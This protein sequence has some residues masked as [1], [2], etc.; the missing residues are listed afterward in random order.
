MISKVGNALSDGW[1]EGLENLSSFDSATASF[2]IKD[3]VAQSNDV[4]VESS[5]F[6][7]SG[8]GEI[9]ML[10]RALDFKFDPA[11]MAGGDQATG[12][13]VQ[14]VVKGSWN[15]PKIYPDV[16]GILDDPEGAYDTLRGLGVSGKT[17]KKIEKS[18]KKLLNNLFGN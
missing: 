1:G 2:Q 9:D 10:R 14:V 18:G 6:Q 16:A 4:K 13:P 15:K 8:G 12:L 3:G 5:A 7:I 17:L 11:L